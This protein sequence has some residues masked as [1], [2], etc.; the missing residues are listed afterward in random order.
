LRHETASLDRPR[1]YARVTGC[2]LD[3]YWIPVAAGTSRPQRASLRAWEAFEAARARR[4]RAILVHSALKIVPGE[5]GTRTLELMPAFVRTGA[6][7][8]VTGAV[9]VRGADRLTLFRYQLVLL[10]AEKLPDEAWA[11][12]EPLRLADDCAAIDRLLALAPSAPNHVWGRRVRGTAEMWTS[13]SVIS[14]LLVRAGIDPSGAG[15]PP[16]TR[17]PG[18]EAGLRLARADG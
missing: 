4:S 15:P 18:W 8:L 17:A 3:L 12:G 7:P 16:G 10:P 2:A 6:A 5:G 9:G 14:W 1:Y 13:D 11:I